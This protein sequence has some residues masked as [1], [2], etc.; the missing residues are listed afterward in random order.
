MILILLFVFE[1]KNSDCFAKFR[2]CFTAVCRLKN[3]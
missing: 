1:Y 3:T 2:I